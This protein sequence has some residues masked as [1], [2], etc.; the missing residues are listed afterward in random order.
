M[1]QTAAAGFGYRGT[2]S[3]FC[4]PGRKR[5]LEKH[6]EKYLNPGHGAHM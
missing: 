4:S 1:P 6:P 2:T 3:Y 5:D